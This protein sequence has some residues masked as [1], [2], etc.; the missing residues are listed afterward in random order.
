MQPDS[1][2]SRPTMHGAKYF[3]TVAG[4]IG[5]GKSSLARLIGER[6]GWQVWFESV[7][8]NPY[9]ADFY[10]DMQRWSF[11][12]QVFFL[13]HRAHHHL[14]LAEQPQS[15]IQDRS[16]FEDRYVFAPALHRM[17]NMSDRDFD[18]YVRLYDLVI[19]KL[20]PPSLLIYLR[21]SVPA[22]LERIGQR[23]R[24]ME[25]GITAEYLT[26]LDE[27]YEQWIPRFNLCP[28]LSVPTD[29][30]DFVR[31]E[32]H[33]DLITERILGRLWGREEIV[34]PDSP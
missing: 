8:D 28:V 12:L 13:G 16:I 29:R 19:A 10:R 20:P 17:G 26:L 7:E 32:R 1:R 14:R 30:L 15:V 5:A 25:R 3:V 21:A 34:F 6:L 24:D 2:E 33:S 22:L 4:N 27:L 23:G 9:L 31:S 18:A 11:H